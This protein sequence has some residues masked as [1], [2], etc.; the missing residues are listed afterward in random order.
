MALSE[1]VEL[2][3]KTLGCREQ[4]DLLDP[5]SAPEMTSLHHP[6]DDKSLRRPSFS[7][8]PPGV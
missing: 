6:D 4:E 5:A 2:D 1:V 8:W 3:W 7:S